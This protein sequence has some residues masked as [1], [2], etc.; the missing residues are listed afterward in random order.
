MSEENIIWLKQKISDWGENYL[1]E[2]KIILDKIQIIVFRNCI[3]KLYFEIV[4]R[5]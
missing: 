5:Q 4:F 3:S 1:S 2:E